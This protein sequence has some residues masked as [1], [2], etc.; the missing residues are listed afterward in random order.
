MIRDGDNAMRRQLFMTAIG[1]VF[2]APAFALDMPARKAGL[3]EIKMVFEGRNLPATVMRQ[4]IDAATDKLMNANISGP[5]QQACSKQDMQNSGG[6]I[7][8]DSV[9]TFGPTTTTSHAVVTGSFDSAYTMKV[10]S[11][12]A[13]GPPLPGTAPGAETHMTIEAKRLGA[14]EAGQRP[15]DVMMSNGKTMNVLDLPKFGGAPKR[16]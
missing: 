14:C 15:G 2:A 12:R 3:W 6:V 1:L 5:A 16:P 11:T 4:C 9:C 10:A 13:G 7:T 8:V